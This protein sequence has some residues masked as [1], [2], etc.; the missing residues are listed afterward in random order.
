MSLSSI[1]EPTG[2]GTHDTYFATKYLQGDRTFYSLDVSVPELVAMIPAPD[3]S[4]P[5]EGNRRINESHARKFADYV[6]SRRDW[7]CPPMLLRSPEGEFT[8]EPLRKVGGTEFG[9]LSIPKLARTS[10]QITDGQ[11]RV[12]GFH[13]AWDKLAEDIEKSREHAARLKRTSD[14]AALIADAERQMRGLKKR[15][16]EIGSQRVGID[17][18]MVDD[19]ADYKQVF[20]DI[21][22]NALG[23]SRAVSVRFDRRKVVNRALETVMT[24]PLLEKRV[25][26]QSDRIT[27]TSQY[28]MGAKHVTDIIRAVQ[29]GPS[30]RISKRQEDELSEI[31][32]A[33]NASRFLDT[34]ADAFPEMAKI[35][36]EEMTPEALRAGSLLGSVVMLR[37]L[38]GTYGALVVQADPEDRWA[39]EDLVEF[40]KS[41][42]NDMTAPVDSESRWMDTGVFIE[43]TM[44]PSARQGD[45]TKLTNTIVDWARTWRS[46]E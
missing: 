14:D 8:F 42:G 16:D 43:G 3:P 38:A 2:Y 11:H 6:R 5:A 26:E 10:L 32:V 17:I 18:L 39:T 45:I 31:T 9:L 4:R 30:R 20:V 35:R 37:A 21:A 34:L 24:H 15:R 40:F 44:A 22:D 12:L 36:D 19:P 41:L 46:A 23:I 13:L 28:L 27:R 25:D 1:P 33:G 29:V 7:V